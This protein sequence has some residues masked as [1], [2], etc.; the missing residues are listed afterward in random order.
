MGLLDLIRRQVTKEARLIEQIDARFAE[1]LAGVMTRVNSQIRRLLNDLE[2]KRGRLVATKAS[3]GRTL[4]LRTEL[5]TALETAGFGELMLAAVDAP[6]DRLAAVVLDGRSIAAQAARVTP[7]ALDTLA[8]LKTVRLADLLELGEHTTTALWR[9]TIDGVLGLR[10][11]PDLVDELAAV[12]EVSARQGRTLYDTAVSTYGRA[13]EQ[14][15]V[16]GEGADRFL[17]IGPDDTET[18]PFCREHVDQILT[19][20]EISALDNGQL[21]NVLLTGGGYNCR[22]SPPAFGWGEA[23]GGTRHKWQFVGSLSARELGMVA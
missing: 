22:A 2:T 10:P 11:V 14:I 12:T 21:P 8:A 17:Y 7:V 20:D 19:R 5:A 6:L 13:V 9:S 18:R 15:G 4:R 23:L 1:E 3:L 16:P